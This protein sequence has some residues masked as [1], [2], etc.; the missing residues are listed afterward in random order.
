MIKI[1]KYNKEY[2]ENNKYFINEKARIYYRE[3][4]GYEI[5]RK[6]LRKQKEE[7]R[8]LKNLMNDYCSGN[9]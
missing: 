1:S 7:M 9:F 2:Y 8:K 3:N 6:K 5:K 4:F